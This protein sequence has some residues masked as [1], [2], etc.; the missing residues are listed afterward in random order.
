MR[1]KIALLLP[2]FALALVLTGLAQ[3]KIGYTNIELVM[4]YM[5]ESKS[6][7]QQ[8]G[9][10][11]KK[12]AEKLK[13]KDDYVKQKY[14]EYLEKKERGTMS[15]DEQKRLETELLQLDEEVQ[16]MA[17]D[18]EYD[19]MAK[20]QELLEPVLKKLQDAIDSVAETG[21]YSYIL[22]QTTSA[23][24]STILHGPEDADVTEAIFAKLGMKMP[25][26]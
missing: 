13:V 4:A 10:Y 15:P 14:Q 18:S 22:N 23:G 1:I 19:L 11:Q 9:T 8:L 25:E 7:E 2:F 20:R 5:P 16:K 17:A 26:E 3:S 21:G 12:L 24:V 6:I